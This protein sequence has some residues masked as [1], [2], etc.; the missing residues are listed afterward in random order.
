MGVIRGETEERQRERE[1][2][3]RKAHYQPRA[4][5]FFGHLIFT[6]HVRETMY[7][8]IGVPYSA[9]YE[10]API[11]CAGREST[12]LPALFHTD[13]LPAHFIGAASVSFPAVR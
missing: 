2:D 3:E 7:L 11:K 13:S 12:S 9:S 5:W 8:S 1:S 4:R 10:A 6:H